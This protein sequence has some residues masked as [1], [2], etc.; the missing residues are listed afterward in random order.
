MALIDVL[1]A[2]DA[3]VHELTTQDRRESTQ[4][5]YNRY[6]LGITMNAVEDVVKPAVAAGATLAEAFADA[7]NPTR[8]MHSVARR[9]R[10][11]LGVERGRWVRCPVA[12]AACVCGQPTREGFTHTTGS[13]YRTPPLTP[14]Q[15]ELIPATYP[16]GMLFPGAGE[17]A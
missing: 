3:L 2:M 7:F 4:R 14:I 10:L 17:V 15:A 5:G 1:P 8:G 16:G 12:A 9:L 6:A 11:P 13:C